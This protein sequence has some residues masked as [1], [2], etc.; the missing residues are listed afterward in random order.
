MKHRLHGNSALVKVHEGPGHTQ[1][2]LYSLSTEKAQ[3]LTNLIVM[4][5][6]RGKK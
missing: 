1:K 6:I 2:N 4:L 5:Y 3:V